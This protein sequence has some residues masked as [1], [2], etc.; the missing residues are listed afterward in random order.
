MVTGKQTICITELKKNLDPVLVESLL[1]LHAISG[2]DTTSRPY[3]IGKSTVLTKYNTLQ[4]SATTFMSPLSS[5]QD[6][7]K[8]GEE[9]LLVKYGCTSSP[10]LNAARVVKFQLKVATS[11]GY[12]SPEKLPP[13]CDV[14]V[15]HSLRTYHQVQEW[16]GNSTNPV[17]WGWVKSGI[18]LV[19]I[20]MEKAAAP[21]SLIKIIR[22]NCG[23]NC[24]KKTCTCRK[25]G[26][27]CTPACGNCKGITCS[28]TNITSETLEDD[29]VTENN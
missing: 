7:E 28:N 26:I 29:D 27:N 3:G 16:R 2:C 10:N 1:F 13:T 19:P 24:K 22:C 11:A 14:A 18:G 8:A 20:R 5:K 23:G 15:F 4:H 25:N 9:A 6:I 17:D 21:E 12:V